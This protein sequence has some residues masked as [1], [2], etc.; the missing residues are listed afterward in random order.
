MQRR[1]GRVFLIGALAGG[2]WLASALVA[3]RAAAAGMLALV[4]GCSLL[5]LY[6]K[7]DLVSE[8]EAA[9]RAA[10]VAPL[11]AGQGGGATLADPA[12]VTPTGRVSRI[13]AP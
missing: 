2:L 8:R 12:A 6:N 10:L 7:W 4:A 11:V 3:S 13:I 5:L 9:Y 1:R